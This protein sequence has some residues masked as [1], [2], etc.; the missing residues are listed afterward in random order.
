MAGAVKAEA[1]A[2]RARNTSERVC[3]VASDG[4]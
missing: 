1:A 2:A 3:I 4:D